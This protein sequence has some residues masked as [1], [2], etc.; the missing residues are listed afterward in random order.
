MF[1]SDARHENEELK[2]TNCPVETT[3]GDGFSSNSYK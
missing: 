3:S 2:K 1:A